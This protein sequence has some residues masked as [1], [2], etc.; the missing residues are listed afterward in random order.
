MTQTDDNAVATTVE[1]TET[2]QELIV[3]RSKPAMLKVN[4]QELKKHL[5]TEL[6]KYD[7]VVTQDTVKGAKELATTLNKLAGEIDTRRKEEVALVS[8]PIKLFYAQMK[9]LVTMAKD[10]RQKLLDQVKKFEDDT[11]KLCGV[12][13]EQ[14]CTIQWAEQGVKSEFYRAEYDDL[15]LISNVTATGS[16]TQKAKDTLSMRVRDDRAVQDKVEMRLVML[17]NASLKAGLSTALSRV[18]VAHFLQAD[19]ATYEAGLQRLLAVEVQR[20]EEAEEAMRR[21][22]EKERLQKEE[23]ERHEAD[24]RRRV[25]EKLAMEQTVKPQDAPVA[26]KTAPTPV[27]T[28]I[29]VVNSTPRAQEAASVAVKSEVLPIVPAG[30]KFFFITATFEIMAPEGVSADRVKAKLQEKLEAAGIKSLKSIIV[31]S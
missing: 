30:K 7:L 28:P 19:G 27:P 5:A 1:T 31:S 9:E 29:Q 21:K 8:E 4:F 20:Q 13:L 25:A 26:E 17:E 14:F 24:L 6:Q 15:I 18:H 16:L 12:L 2:T 23:R 11:R 3:V 22:L 10:G